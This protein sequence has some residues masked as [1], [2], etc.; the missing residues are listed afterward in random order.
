MNKYDEL[1]ADQCSRLGISREQW[2]EQQAAYHR[3]VT[4]QASRDPKARTW[5]LALLYPVSAYLILVG[6]TPGRQAGIVAQGSLVFISLIWISW[7]SIRLYIRERCKYRAW[8]GYALLALALVGF[9]V[10]VLAL[11]LPWMQL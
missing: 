1:V 2:E 6:L 3:M 11:E 4:E 5:G 7:V 8:V 9:A 10:I